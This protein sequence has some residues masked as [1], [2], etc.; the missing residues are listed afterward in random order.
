MI[1]HSVE[2]FLQKIALPALCHF[3]DGF[4]YCRSGREQQT[5]WQDCHD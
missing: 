2:R 5:A 1:V 4:A 3:R